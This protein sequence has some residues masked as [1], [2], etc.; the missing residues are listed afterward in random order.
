[1]LEIEGVSDQD[2]RRFLE[3]LDLADVAA[4][5]DACEQQDGGVETTIEVECPS[6][7]GLQDVDLPF[8]RGFFFPRARRTT[9]TP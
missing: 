4:L 5:L 2:R 7:G 9:A 6:C 8:E 3:D 1:V